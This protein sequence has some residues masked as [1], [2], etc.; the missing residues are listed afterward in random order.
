MQTN[1]HFDVPLHHLQS[2]LLKYMFIIF[3]FWLAWHVSPITLGYCCTTLPTGHLL[4]AWNFVS[5][6]KLFVST[7]FCFNNWI[8]TTSPTPTEHLLVSFCSM[9][10]SFGCYLPISGFRRIPLKRPAKIDWLWLFFSSARKYP[11]WKVGFPSFTK[12]GRM[13]CCG[14]PWKNPPCVNLLILLSLPAIVHLSKQK[15]K[16]IHQ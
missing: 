15:H 16:L 3:Q 14:T 6:M 13:N 10:F 5:T 2:S 9:D 11:H 8:L 1:I 4:G 7:Y 12:D